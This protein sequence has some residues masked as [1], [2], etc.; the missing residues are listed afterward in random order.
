VTVLTLTYETPTCLD[1]LIPLHTPIFQL[2]P[3]SYHRIKVP[4]AAFNPLLVEYS[5][6]F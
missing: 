4:K 1:A 5:A 2:V 3:V 6:S